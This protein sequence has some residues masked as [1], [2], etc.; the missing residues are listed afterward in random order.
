MRKHAVLMIVRIKSEECSS[1]SDRPSTSL[2]P[3]PKR[4]PAVYQKS[5]GSSHSHSSAS[6]LN[7]NNYTFS[8]REDVRQYLPD[9]LGRVLARIW[10]DP[11][12]HASFSRNP[13]LTLRNNGVVLPENMSV[14]FQKQNTERPRIVVF[15]QKPGS[16]FKLRVLYL[17]L[18]MMAGR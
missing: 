3:A 16:K 17:Q 2:V 15:E 9:I 18:V 6:S 7:E 10:I 8:S 13:E 4:V 12:F 1:M 5:S 14:E 11:E